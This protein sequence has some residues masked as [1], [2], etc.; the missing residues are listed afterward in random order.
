MSMISKL[1]KPRFIVYLLFITLCVMIAYYID[2]IRSLP[3][4]ITYTVEEVESAVHNHIATLHPE[5][6]NTVAVICRKEK[7]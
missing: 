3:P 7:G 2:Y 1:V 5:A 6:E 4:L